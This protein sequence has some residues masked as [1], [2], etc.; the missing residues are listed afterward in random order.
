MKKASIE[1]KMIYLSCFFCFEGLNVL[2]I[3][4]HTCSM[5]KEE[6]MREYEASDKNIWAALT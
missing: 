6:I 3:K 4:K 5:T 2:F 1:S